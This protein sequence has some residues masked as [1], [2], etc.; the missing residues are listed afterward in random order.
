MSDVGCR[1]SDES[2]RSDVSDVGQVE[3]VGRVAP[4]ALRETDFMGK[5]QYSQLHDFRA[6][7]ER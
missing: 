5:I 6:L 4:D 3:Q 1:M 7:D 2:D